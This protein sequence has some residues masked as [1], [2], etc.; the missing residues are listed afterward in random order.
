MVR[1]SRSTAEENPALKRLRSFLWLAGLFGVVLSLLM[2]NAASIIVNRTLRQITDHARSR[3]TTSAAAP[4][5]TPLGRGDSGGLATSIGKLAE[6]LQRAVGE[7]AGERDRFEA[8]LESMNEAVLALDE[9]HQITLVNRAAMGLLGLREDPVG[10]RAGDV[11]PVVEFLD[12]LEAAV[13]R[14]VSREFDLPQ[15]VPEVGAA[16]HPRRVLANAAPAQATGGQVIVMH[17]VTELRRLETMRRDFVDNVSHELRTPVSVIM[18]NTETLLS[19]GAD[20]AV[21]ARRFLDGLFRNAERLSRLINDLLDISRLEAGKYTM[22]LEP[23]PLGQAVLRVL[24][25]VESTARDKSQRLEVDLEED[26]VALADPK[27]LDQVLTNLLDNAIKYTPEVG[28]IAIV[29]RHIGQDPVLSTDA[30]RIEVRDDGPGIPPSQ[31]VRVFERFYRVDAG[32]S[33]GTGGTGLGLSIVKHL[34]AV[35]GG[36][37]GVKANEPHGSIFWVILPAAEPSAPREIGSS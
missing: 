4:E 3:A 24:E 6:E 13:R 35:M 36:R 20:D 27:S 15:H 25:A 12:M 16:A 11:L 2:G 29:A 33:R 8:V 18:A 10:R 23:V 21:Q 14:P 19:M 17:D 34:V 32:R 28:H 7:L 31:R 1:L 30:L 5:T 9:Q 37:V 22:I 26:L